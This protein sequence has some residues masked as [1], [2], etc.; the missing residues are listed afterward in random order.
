[1]KNQEKRENQ[2]PKRRENLSEQKANWK[3]IGLFAGGALLLAF[4]VLSAKAGS[5]KEIVITD[6]DSVYDYRLY[7]GTWF[8]RKKG[9]S[10]W[11]DMQK[12][13]TPENYE[14]AISRLTSF[15]N[16]Q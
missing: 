4:V 3:K 5:E 9:V 12:A 14:L 11:T 6:H 16:T 7:N 8:T 13:L 15:L 10:E 2:A 1:M